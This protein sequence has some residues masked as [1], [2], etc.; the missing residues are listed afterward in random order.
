[1]LHI[2]QSAPTRAMA[3]LNTDAG[4]GTVHF[5]NAFCHRL[6]KLTMLPFLISG[7][8]LAL[9]AKKWG[10]VKELELKLP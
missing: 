1:M 10:V 9:P 2:L 8:E 4:A 7:G 3:H 6:Q 5:N